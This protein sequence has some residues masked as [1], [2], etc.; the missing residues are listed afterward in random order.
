MKA[1]T[2]IVAAAVGVCVLVA[3]CGCSSSDRLSSGA[4]AEHGRVV[5]FQVEGMAC[6]NCAN[7]IA[8]ELREVPGVT[9]ASVDFDRSS[10]AV[11]LDDDDPAT[12][13][14]L[15]AAVSH[16]KT[17]HFALEYD[18]DCLDPE[19]RKELQGDH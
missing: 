18:P 12:M 17:T 10:A 16:W 2:R 3:V 11:V 4:M 14:E 9:D 5:T 19:R 13:A 1:A 6:R 7:E 15:Q 8:R